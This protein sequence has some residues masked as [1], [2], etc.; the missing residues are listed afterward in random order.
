METTTLGVVVVAGLM[1]L[2]VIL[3]MAM[4]ANLYRKAGPHEALVVYG[5]R[6]PVSLKAGAW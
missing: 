1:V 6:E 2:T 5:F 3:V 4:F